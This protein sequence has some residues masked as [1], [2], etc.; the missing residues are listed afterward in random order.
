MANNGNPI[1]E[2]QKP[3]KP[4]NAGTGFFHGV[5]SIFGLGEFYD[6]YGDLQTS[7][8]NAQQKLQDTYNSLY[9]SALYAQNKVDNELWQ[10]LNAN[11]SL[12]KQNIEYYA[13]TST[14]NYYESNI[15]IKLLAIL[16]LIIIFFI[17]IK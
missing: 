12:I 6:T 15:F 9:G 17:L 4:V 11:S 2:V 3:D 13:L 7:A 8:T 5:L 1:M 10:Y 16:S 14:N